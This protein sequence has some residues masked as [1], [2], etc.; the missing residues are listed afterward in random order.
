MNKKYFIIF[1]WLFLVI[2]LVKFC[3]VPVLND[4]TRISGKIVLQRKINDLFEFRASDFDR[5]Q[6]EYPI[7]ENIISKVASSLVR[8]EAPIEFIKFLEREAE[9]LD[10]ELSPMNMLQGLDDVWM[11]IGFR[12]EVKGSFPDCLRF[13]ARIERSYWFIKIFKIDVERIAEKHMR[14]K[15]YKDLHIGDV[16]FSIQLKVFAKQDNEFN[17][18]EN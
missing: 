12:M 1:I 6:N 17:I 8:P 4:M 15:E 16:K 18:G 9:D 2:V 14:L 7:Y 10:I 3:L 11:P 5:F 13:L